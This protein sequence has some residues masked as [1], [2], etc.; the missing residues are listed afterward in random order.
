M[1]CPRDLNSGWNAFATSPKN[2]L[3]DNPRLAAPFAGRVRQRSRQEL[4]WPNQKSSQKTN[5][6]KPANR[7]SPKKKSSPASTTSWHLSAANSPGSKSKRSTPSTLP[8][9]K[10]PSPTSSAL[11]P[12]SSSTTSCSAP[13][14]KKAAPAALTSAIISTALSPTSPPATFH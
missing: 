14:G 12:S 6:S 11:I 3:T 1:A 2:A 7:F 13:T 10:S 9:A 5:G 8:T 4:S